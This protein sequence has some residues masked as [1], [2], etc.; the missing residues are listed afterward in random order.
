MG[1]EG[2]ELKPGD[3]ISVD[4][5]LFALNNYV[6]MTP[7]PPNIIDKKRKKEIVRV[8][9]KYKNNLSKWLAFLAALMVM[10]SAIRIKDN[11]KTITIE[12][13]VQ[14]TITS[15]IN[16]DNL[17]YAIGDMSDQELQD[18]INNIK[19]KLLFEHK[20]YMKLVI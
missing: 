9:R 6:I 15:Y 12:Q 4:E 3:Y 19:K 11:M 1:N 18:T 17:D 13:Q 10:L 7:T 8:S 20:F 5:L 14:T 2:I 16:T